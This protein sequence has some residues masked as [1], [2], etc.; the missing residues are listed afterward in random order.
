[1]CPERPAR[2]IILRDYK[3]TYNELL[4]E[5]EVFLMVFVDKIQSGFDVARGS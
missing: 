2:R 5:Q 3:F 4:A 1:M